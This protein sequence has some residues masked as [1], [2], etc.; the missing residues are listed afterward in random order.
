M[1]LRVLYKSKNSS[2]VS[3]LLSTQK[4]WNAIY[5]LTSPFSGHR[6][7]SQQQMI[8]SCAAYSPTSHG[9]PQDD[10]GFAPR[11]LLSFPPKIVHFNVTSLKNDALPVTLLELPILTALYVFLVPSTT[12]WYWKISTLPIKLPL[13]SNRISPIVPFVVTFCC[14]A[15]SVLQLVSF[16]I[17]QIWR[18]H[19]DN[20]HKWVHKSLF[21]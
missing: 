10:S 9:R 13:S 14:T 7:H 11:E 2:T 19:T 6:L 15:C 8:G 12:L 18:S 4:Y 3:L 5:K 16:S 20:H 1:K 21:L 17:P